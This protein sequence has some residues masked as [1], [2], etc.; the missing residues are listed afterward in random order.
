M[1]R[2][3]LFVVFLAISMLLPGMAWSGEI[4]TSITLRNDY[5]KPNQD[6]SLTIQSFF[7]YWHYKKYGAGLELDCSNN[8]FRAKPYFTLD[9]GKHF[10]GVFGINSDSAGNDYF[11]TGLWYTD[12][13]KKLGLIADV[14][15][16]WSMGEQDD[17]L[18]IFV[19]ATFP[20]NAKWFTGAGIQYDYFWQSQANW[21]LAG[22]VLGYKID[23]NW[24]IVGRLS[25]EWDWGKG[26]QAEADRLRLELK[27]SF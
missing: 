9:F 12:S 16:Y 14:R 1:K 18:D 25:H 11:L 19:L 15:N 27:T 20:I 13:W 8:F 24:S 23:D 26:Y 6:Q 10:S 17:Y 21:F 22:P 3:L 4:T 2:N 5:L 7:G